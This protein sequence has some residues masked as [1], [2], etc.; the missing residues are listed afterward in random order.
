MFPLSHSVGKLLPALGK[1]PSSPGTLALLMTNA[2]GY[3]AEGEE[4]QVHRLLGGGCCLCWDQTPQQLLACRQWCSLQL[5]VLRSW[6]SATQGKECT[7]IPAPWAT[8][9][10]VHV[11]F[12]THASL[13]LTH[14]LT[15]A[16][17]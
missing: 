17:N 7:V 15:K 12:Y 13:F 16:L 1:C 11:K 14:T 10:H 5:G 9:T 4:E 2:E 6:G 3:A 8:H